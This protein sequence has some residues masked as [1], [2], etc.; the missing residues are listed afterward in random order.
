MTPVNP[1][2]EGSESFR[3][4]SGTPVLAF[5]LVTM[6]FAAFAQD[7][8]FPPEGAFIPTPSC[9]LQN[10]TDTPLRACSQAEIAA[11]RKDVEHWRKEHLLRIGYNGDQYERPELRWTQSNYIQVQMMVEDRFFYDPAKGKYTVDRYLDDLEKRY[12][13]IDS[14]L[15]WHVY[16]N[17]GVD[18]RNQ[19]DMLR[20]MPGG[21][22]A[23]K[24]VVADFHRRGVRVLFPEIIWD[25]GTRDEGK[26]DWQAVADL[27]S[28]IGADG[29]NGDTLFGVP[30]VFRTAS[31]QVGHPLA[32]EP[33]GPPADEALAWNNLTWSDLNTSFSP[34]VNRT[35]WLE[36]RHMAHISDRWN[37]D[38]TDDLQVA[39]FNGIGYLSWEN[40][41]SIWNGITPRDGE[42]IRRVATMERTLSQFLVSD[43]WEPLVPTLRFGVFASRWQR[44]DETLWTVV[45]RNEYDV[46]ERQLAIPHE[47][48][49]RYF[50][51]YHGV[52]L[53]PQREGSN[54]VLAFNLE[55]HGFGA[56]LA[57]PREP[58][59]NIQALMIKMEQLSARALSSYSKTWE[60][61]PQHMVEIEKTTSSSDNS[62][63]RIKIPAADYLFRVHGIEIE[64]DD[65]AGVDVQYPWESTAQRFHEHK[66]HIQPF[67]IDKYPVTNREFRQ[68]LEA[69]KYDPQDKGN[70]LKDWTNGDFPATWEKKPVTWV[71][72][73]D[74]RAY[75]GW[76]GARLPH[77][78]EWQYAAQGNDERV[79]PWGNSWNASVVPQPDTGR[80]LRGPDDVG[81]HP[82]GASPFGVMDMV[83]DV[84]QWTD[85]FED[86]HTRTAILRGGSYYQP[87]GSMWYFPQ[88]YRA[89]EHGKLLLMAPSK[90]R[91]GTIGFRCVANVN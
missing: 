88:A 4:R 24:E 45:N 56:V 39:W 15:I 65:N 46:Q 84:W 78:W 58:D 52:E 7:T 37:R 8:N 50:D 29:I 28:E 64:G 57:T 21:L 20:A 86:E 22:Q 60:P 33:E 72:L 87:Q 13:G 76:A 70:F 31:D 36:P 10:N 41:W 67:Q 26:A 74:A 14:V 54:D 9:H 6:S 80:T 2:S 83:G 55:A 18:N 66:L 17:I 5:A 48:P 79:Y 12:G 62:R 85:E 23:L 34:A 47:G 91:A 59:R 16:P 35:K 90:D 40:I 69:A 73:E 1:R 43:S 68:F 53:E 63:D 51:L 49:M 71:S 89:D 25:Q 77:E 30:R 11:W 27:M 81:A 32:L 82:Q 42:A 38:K 75:C 44:D 19:Y 61:L 3:I